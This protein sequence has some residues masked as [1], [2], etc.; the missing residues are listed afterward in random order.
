MR[1]IS[2]RLVLIS[3]ICNEPGWTGVGDCITGTGGTCMCSGSVGLPCC[4]D[5]EKFQGALV[6]YLKGQVNVEVK[7]ICPVVE[8]NCFALT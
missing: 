6:K 2:F 7:F 3:G 5:K 1:R 8:S 4:R